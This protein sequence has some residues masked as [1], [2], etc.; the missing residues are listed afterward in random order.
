MVK[1]NN[2]NTSSLHGLCDQRLSKVFSKEANIVIYVGTIVMALIGNGLLIAAYRRMKETIMLLIT[3][4]AA[5]DILTA[6]FLPTRMFAAEVTDSA[7]WQVPGIGGR[8]LC[9]ICPFLSDI[10]IS[11]S[12]QSLVIIAIERSL[13]IL[14][15]LKAR[16]IT[17]RTRRFLIASTWIVAMAS[18]TPYFF[19][20]DLDHKQICLMKWQFYNKSA[21]L[22]YS[23]F[24]SLTVI[25]LPLIALVIIYPITVFYLIMRRD[26]MAEHRN[27]GG[28]KRFRQS[29]M[30]LF[31]LATATVMSFIIFWLPFSTIT[32]LDFFIPEK[33]PKCNYLFMAIYQ[34]AHVLMISYSA[35]NPFICFIF[36]RNFRNELRNICKKRKRNAYLATN[37]RNRTRSSGG[38]TS[39]TMYCPNESLQM[40][41]H[42]Q[43][44]SHSAHA[45]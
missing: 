13:A 22:R 8:I 40:S 20:F 30:K 43:M 23:I 37:N 4:M 27:G 16:L 1:T 28:K 26:I 36:L 35:V 7:A 45:F 29:S 3:N 18:H 24:L 10:S 15:P 32:L 19:A 12:T 14:Y 34:V 42:T 39:C 2:S 9:K 33:L 25:I 17:V 44:S 6:I 5:S 31:R 21:F 38:S 11:V 41:S